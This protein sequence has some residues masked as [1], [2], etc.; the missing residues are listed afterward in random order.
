MVD[1]GNKPAPTVEFDLPR[2]DEGKQ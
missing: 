1:P 2:E